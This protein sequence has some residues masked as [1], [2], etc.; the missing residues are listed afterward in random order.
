MRSEILGLESADYWQS[1]LDNFCKNQADIYFSPEYYQLANEN[2]EGE[3]R[4]F[5]FSQK[6][7]VAIYPFMMN[8]INRLNIASLDDEYYDIQGAYG[9]NG[10]LSTSHDP[11][12]KSAFYH[13]FE[14][15]CKLNNIVAE[16]TRFHPVLGN[17]HFSRDNMEVL[18]NRRTLCVDLKPSYEDIWQR[19]Y[20]SNNRNMIR[21]A[22][23]AGLSFEESVKTDVE[24]F[25]DLYT[26]TMTH[27]N[28]EKFY[29][30]T[31]SY[32]NQLSALN[33]HKQVNVYQNGVPVA[34]LILL[35]YGKY[36][37]YHLAGRDIENAPP[38][39]A[40]LV[41]DQAV[42]VAKE[43]GCEYLHLGGGSSSFGEDGLFRFKSGFTKETSDF[44]IGKK[45]HNYNIYN[46][47]CEA[48][49]KYNPQNTKKFNNLL[50]KYRKTA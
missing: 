17:H 34:S 26:T 28:A 37:H 24:S 18:Y 9:Y 47:I 48:W 1:L 39:A 14:A 8:S 43:N 44:F 25:F 22:E 50:L 19:S 6:G 30:F 12:F 36:A 35:I 21:R 15:Y 20:N 49:E 16:F 33:S 2:S 46:K 3:V 13:H 40:N 7:D 32:F 5:V 11:Q 29:F 4:C 31:K 10:V 42:K 45:V 23:R 27:V 38:G 41:L